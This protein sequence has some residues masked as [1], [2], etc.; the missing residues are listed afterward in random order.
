MLLLEDLREG[1]MPIV[2]L[3]PSEYYERKEL[4]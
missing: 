3:I 4:C 2:A 1:K